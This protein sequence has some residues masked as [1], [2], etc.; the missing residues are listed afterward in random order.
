MSGVIAVVERLT[1]RR[2]PLA[3]TGSSV[4]VHP[5]RSSALHGVEHGLV[6]D[7][8]RDEVPP[9]GRLERL[10]GAAQ[11]E[12]VGLG[13]AAREH[14]VARLGVDQRGDGRRASSTTRLGPLA[15]RVDGRR[16]AELVAEHAD[17]RVAT[18]SG[19][20]GVVAL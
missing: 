15:E 17:H 20:A 10:G 3:S 7:A 5:R 12:V 1:A 2:R 9:A 8:R 13:P 4:T 18:T 14:D 19:A 16:V 6:L 11:R